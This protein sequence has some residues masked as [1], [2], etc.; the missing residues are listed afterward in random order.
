[1]SHLD[2]WSRR[3]GS[4]WIYWPACLAG[5]TLIAL[6]VLGPEAERR[7]AIERHC[8]IMETEVAAL[9]EAHSQLA[10]SAH[11]LENDPVYIEA[12]AVRD[13]NVRRPG[14]EALPLP[15]RLRAETAEPPAPPAPPALPP[16]VANVAR[17]TDPR[18]Q[19]GAMVVG[20]VLLA[21]GIVFSLPT[22][23]KPVPAG[24]K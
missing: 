22:R 21:V 3:L 24:N 5:V 20:I 7:L 12:V 10:A 4:G 2:I 11:A 17:F 8:G 18:F 13:Q 6:A 15:Q 23:A 14:E 16:I 19:F 9:K 1:M